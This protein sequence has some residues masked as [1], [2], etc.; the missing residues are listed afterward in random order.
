MSKDKYKSNFFAKNRGSR[1]LNLQILFNAREK[2]LRTAYCFL[3]KMF[4]VECSLVRL[5]E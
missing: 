2:M 4:F 5:Y 1:F 3:R